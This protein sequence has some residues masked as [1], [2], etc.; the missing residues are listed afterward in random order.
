MK[1]D[2]QAYQHEKEIIEARLAKLEKISM[3]EK[4]LCADAKAENFNN[5]NKK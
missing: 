3:R 4:E 1:K 2:Y 5:M